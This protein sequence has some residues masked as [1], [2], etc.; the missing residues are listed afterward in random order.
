MSGGLGFTPIGVTT[1]AGFTEP[2]APPDP[3]DVLPDGSRW[4]DPATKDWSPDTDNANEWKRMPETRQR[5]LLALT[6][7]AGSSSVLFDFGIRLPRKMGG[8][9]ERRATVAVQAALRQLVVVEKRIRID[10]V[11]VERTAQRAQIVV[12]YTDLSTGAPSDPVR[13]NV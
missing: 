9:F 10:S 4:I 1:P 5:V 11:S 12:S 7:L 13:V 2:L 8:D 6:T 3:P